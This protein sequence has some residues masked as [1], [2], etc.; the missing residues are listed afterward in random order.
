MQ[1]S[2]A[3]RHSDDLRKLIEQL[4][5]ERLEENLFRGQS[6][7]FGTGRVFGGQVLGQALY[8]ALST[9][10]E[11]VAHSLHAYFLREGDHLAPI[12]F[13]VDRARDGRSFANRRVVAIQRGRPIFNMTASFQ[14][15]Q[16]GPE[17]QDPMPETPAPEAL[18]DLRDFATAE[19]DWM[20]RRYFNLL[21]LSKA[22]D[23][24]PVDP[25]RSLG[26]GVREP[27]QMLWMRTSE[28]LPN[29]IVAHQAFLAFLSDLGLIG[30]VTFPHQRP[31]SGF[32]LASLDHAMWFHCPIRVD[33]WMLFDLHSPWAGGARGFAR[34]SVYRRDGAR[35]ATMAQEGLFRVRRAMEQ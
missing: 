28:R 7:D 11:R 21:R 17:H 5:L 1:E 4:E 20:P 29:D 31:R 14:V 16:E 15:R 30:M 2:E 6:R 18:K 12:V 32:Q 25:E 24:R 23:F 26:G 8:A 9:V 35:A 33:E 34:A 27:R 3:T 19:A 22:L 10:E 13:E